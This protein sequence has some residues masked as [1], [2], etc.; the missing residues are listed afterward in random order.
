MSQNVLPS[1]GSATLISRHHKT[2][3]ARHIHTW[4]DG[5]IVDALFSFWLALFVGRGIRRST[6][7]GPALRTHGV[8][9]ML[10]LGIFVLAVAEFLTR[11][12]G[13]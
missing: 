1:G 6:L 9:A 11:T 4:P 3:G 2:A 5:G 7:V 8:Y 10:W 12:A 13:G